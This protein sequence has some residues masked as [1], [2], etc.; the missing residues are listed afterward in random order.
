MALVPHATRRASFT[1]SLKLRASV[2]H[3]HDYVRY[4]TSQGR[5]IRLPLTGDKIIGVAVSRGNRKYVAFLLA[6]VPTALRQVPSFQEDAHAISA[7]HLPWEELQYGLKRN[8]GISWNPGIGDLDMGNQ[9][10]YVGLYDG[11]VIEQHVRAYAS[12]RG[13][14][15][16]S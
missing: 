4:P 2:R 11:C 9:A 5:T 16:P 13:T 8:F 12:D 3:Y 15:R 6:C 1:G 14:G 7:I 10:L